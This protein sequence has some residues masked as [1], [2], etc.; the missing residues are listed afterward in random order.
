MASLGG[1]ILPLDNQ[2]KIYLAGVSVVLLVGVCFSTSLFTKSTKGDD[3]PSLPKALWLFV[4]ACFLKPHDGD[5]K[6]TQQDALESFYKNQAGVYDATRRGLL[7]GREDMLALAASQLEHRAKK[8]GKVME[9]KR[10][11]WVDVGHYL[12]QQLQK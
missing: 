11:I 6:G 10:R 3:N 8:E 5:K 4:Y 2:S 1:N 7:K 12:S 9:S